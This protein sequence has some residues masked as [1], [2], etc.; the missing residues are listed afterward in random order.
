M[1]FLGIYGDMV[2]PHGFRNMINN[3]ARRSVDRPLAWDYK[4]VMV[5]NGQIVDADAKHRVR[6]AFEWLI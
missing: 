2:V 4:R 6:A 3:D 1:R 5:G